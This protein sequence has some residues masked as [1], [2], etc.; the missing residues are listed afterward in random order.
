MTRV[1]LITCHQNHTTAE[2]DRLA[3]WCS[4]AIDEVRRA[5]HNV[6]QNAKSN[7]AYQTKVHRKLRR[8]ILSKKKLCWTEDAAAEEK[9]RKLT[10]LQGSLRGACNKASHGD[11]ETSSAVAIAISNKLTAIQAL[12]HHLPADKKQKV[13]CSI[14][15]QRDARRLSQETCQPLAELTKTLASGGVLNIRTNT[16]VAAMMIAS[17]N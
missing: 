5:V 12:I 10:S 6:Q 9:L 11:T 3:V 14:E 7:T 1:H 15:E 4:L 17:A 8:V 2:Q 13:F 16:R